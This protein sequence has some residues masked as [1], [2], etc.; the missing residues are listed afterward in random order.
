MPSILAA[1]DRTV[2]NPGARDRPDVISSVDFP[3]PDGP[4]IAVAFP[5]SKL[6]DM[7]L[8]T[9]TF[10]AP[11]PKLRLTSP[12][13]AAVCSTNETRWSL[14]SF[15]V[16]LRDCRRAGRRLGREHGASTLLV[17]MAFA[18]LSLVVL[19]ASAARTIHIVASGDSLTAGLGLPES[20]SFP[21]VLER[22]LREA[23]FAVEINQ[24]RRFRRHHNGRARAAGLVVPDDADLVVVELGGERYAARRRAGRR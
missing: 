12:S 4:T 22:R 6:S 1:F 7:P 8:R 13:E 23:G 15:R 11:A 21:G 2:P 19:G 17:Q 3:Q 10:V 18:V 5:R 9:S 16:S 24:R 20:A 14:A